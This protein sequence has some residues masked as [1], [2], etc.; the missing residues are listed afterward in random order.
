MTPQEILRDAELR[1]G[2][3]ILISE[4]QKIKYRREALMFHTG[5]Q[6]RPCRY[7]EAPADKPNIENC[8]FCRTRAR[9]KINNKNSRERRKAKQK[10]P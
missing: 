6:G 5:K 10:G 4:K 2:L 9:K 1:K 7:C 3:K 8:R